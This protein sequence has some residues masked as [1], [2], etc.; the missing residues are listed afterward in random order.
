MLGVAWRLERERERERAQ[1]SQRTRV[2]A[3]VLATIH[4]AEVSLSKTHSWQFLYKCSYGF[5]LRMVL[6]RLSKN[7]TI[8]L[9]CYCMYVAHVSVALSLSV[10]ND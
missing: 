10:V 7:C 1:F 8:T 2:Q 5:F 6:G 3:S 4:A 9:Q